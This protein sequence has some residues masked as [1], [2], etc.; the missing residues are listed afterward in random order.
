MIDI[1]EHLKQKATTIV[2]DGWGG[3]HPEFD[4]KKF[5]ELIINDVHELLQKH[6]QE[7]PLELCGPILDFY[8]KLVE[9]YHIQ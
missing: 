6:Y 5:A 4:E 7:T 9:R 2:D 8:H 3:I 1:F